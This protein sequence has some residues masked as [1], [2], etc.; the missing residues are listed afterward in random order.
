MAARHLP[1][2]DVVQQ[3][4]IDSTFTPTPQGVIIPSGTQVE[5]VNNSGSPVNITF[6]PNPP[7]TPTL[8]TNITNLANGAPSTPQSPQLTNGSVNYTIGPV[9][10]LANGPFAIQV[11]LS[12]QNGGPIYV[13]VLYTAG[14]GDSQPDP[15]AIPEGGTLEMISLDPH[16]YTVG[17][18]KDPFV[19]PLNQVAQTGNVPHTANGAVGSYPYTL[20]LKNASQLGIGGGKVIIVSS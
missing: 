10:G 15:V 9:G 12:N 8:F 14:E 13:Q 11:G 17:W 20:T 16:T 2:Q 19:T 6:N 3:F 4:T 1:V 5:F 18:T 7:A